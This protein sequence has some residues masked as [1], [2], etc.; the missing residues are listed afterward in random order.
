MR[1]CKK[2]SRNYKRMQKNKG[3]YRKNRNASQIEKKR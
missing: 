1:G 3:K 2:T